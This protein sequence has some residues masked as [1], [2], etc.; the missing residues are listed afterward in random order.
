MYIYVKHSSVRNL[1][2]YR[3][4]DEK[5]FC[6]GGCRISWGR[7]SVRHQ[8]QI[9][10]RKQSGC[11]E[12]IHGMS[13]PTEVISKIDIRNAIELVVHRILLQSLQSVY[14]FLVVTDGLLWAAQNKCISC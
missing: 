4:A 9:A 2:S 13:D 8:T 3:H 12:V 7:C 11:S 6:T 5:V 10:A 1:H 14:N